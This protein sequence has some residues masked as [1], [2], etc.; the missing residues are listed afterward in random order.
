[1]DKIL[2]FLAFAMLAFANLGGIGYF[3]YLWGSVGLALSLAMWTAFKFWIIW[4]IIVILIFII[5]G[6]RSIN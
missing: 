2:L 3:L 4:I 1:M 5:I 6:M